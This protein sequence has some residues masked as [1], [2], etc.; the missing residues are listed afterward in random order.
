M[1][2]NGVAKWKEKV[3]SKEGDLLPKYKC[4]L[5]MIRLEK[6]IAALSQYTKR[7]FAVMSFCTSKITGTSNIY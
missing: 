6:N 7:W 4:K 1:N 2:V 5:N 3:H